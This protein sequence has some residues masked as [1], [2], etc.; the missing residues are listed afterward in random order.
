MFCK[1][2]FPQLHEIASYAHYAQC[3]LR[4]IPLP[5]I[6]IRVAI[7][8]IQGKYYILTETYKTIL[9]SDVYYER[10]NI[11]RSSTTY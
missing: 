7:L 4:E 8:T 10:K 9:V 5:Y 1:Q 6:Q 3:R 2:T 11:E